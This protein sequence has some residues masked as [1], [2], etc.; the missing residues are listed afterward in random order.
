MELL[1]VANNILAFI[2]GLGIIQGFLLSLL[3]YFHTKADKSVNLFLALYI[4]FLSAVMTMPFTFD[5]IGWQNSYVIQFLPLLP[6]ILLYFYIRSFKESITWRKV[7]PH[8]IPVVVYSVLIY[9]NLMSI[10]RIY[11]NAEEIPVE[12]LKK[13]FTL[14]IIVFRTIQ[15]FVYYFLARKSLKSYQRSIHQLYSETSR[16]D[17]NWV[18]FLIN[19]Y[20]LLICAFPLLFPFMLGFPQYFNTFFLTIMAIATPYIYLAT[21]K[22]FTQSTIWQVQTNTNKQIVHDEI[23]ETEK[24][25]ANGS[26]PSNQKSGKT[27]LSPELVKSLVSRIT[28]LMEEDK[29]YQE[30]ELTLH[31]LADKLDAPSYQV[32]IALKEG[33]RR[34]FYDV[35][36]GYRVNEAKRLLMD[37]KNKNFTILSVGFEAGFNSKTAFNTV[38]KKLTGFTP[39]EYR[40][41]NTQTVD[42]I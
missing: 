9:L 28:A 29:L 32:S 39:T 35:I 15:Q 19:G 20:I 8:L 12:G 38:F 24:L 16:I 25:D 2:A 26:E 11:P 23:S 18:R 7:L 1:F 6:G 10:H 34:N 17:L 31:Q 13:P 30:T 41:K 22:G 36:N 40:S 42:H 4:F 21:Y 33:M 37:A 3:L 14:V 5:L 27:T